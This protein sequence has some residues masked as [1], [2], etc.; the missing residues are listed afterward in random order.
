M[1][2]FLEILKTYWGYDSFRSLQDEIILSVAGG[3]DTLGLMPT[4]GGKSLTFQVPVMSMEGICIVVTPLI[5]LMK[6][7]VDNLRDRGIKAAAI[8]SGMS[9]QEIITALENC[10]FGNYKFLYISP[11]RLTTE[12]FL[13]KIQYM[14]VCLLVVDESHCISQWGY[15]FR[16][17]Y[18]NIAAIRDY[19][20]EV[21][22][23]ALTAT[24]TE[25]VVADIQEKLLFREKNVFRKSFERINIAYIVRKTEDK[26]YEMIHILSRIEGS[27][28]VYVR[29]RKKT[30][31]I[32][33][34]LSDHHI[35]ADFFHAGLSSDEKIIRQ[36]KWKS[37]ETRVMVCTNAFG[38]GIDKPDVRIVIHY[39]MPGSLEEYFQEAGRAG[40]DGQKSYA[41]ALYSEKD[42]QR[43]KKRVDDEFPARDFI[44][45]I[46][47]K[48]AYYF[49]L[50]VNTG[51]QTTYNFDLED[52]C[53]VFKFSFSQ[54]HYALKLLQLAGYIEYVEETDKQS[55]LIFTVNRDDLYDLSE[56]NKKTE[57]LIQVIL[58]SYTG[59]FAE[60]VY[61]NESLL[62]NRSGL[63]HHEVYETLKMLSKRRIIH[64][65]PAQKIPM[66]IYLQNRID[67]KY[68][69]I[70]A[71]VYEDRKNR[72]K[73]RIEGVIN[74]GSSESRCRSRL[75]L[76]YFGERS[77]S[78]CGH[79]DVCLKKKQN[80]IPEN[81]HKKI[82]NEILSLIGK[83]RVSFED[84]ISELSSYP[85]N[86]IVKLI[87]FLSDSGKIVL[88][89]NFVYIKE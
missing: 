45:N 29:S 21:P 1:D 76:E 87:R 55:R 58:R 18:L 86:L 14:N 68:L 67:I 60:Y 54:T 62:A 3:K 73:N 22:V 9:R 13:V 51:E 25:D 66:I 37:G 56:F 4:G 47:E 23:L 7:Q 16:P 65:I 88:S 10:I 28:I 72:L 80:D 63:S 17:S 41:V 77:S 57:F 78:D 5:A 71:S 27:G 79:C 11:E 31:E 19:F 64:Y 89:G 20:P 2:K 70:P 35:N 69:S 43:L 49:Q 81:Q 53:A 74:Y 15:D 61:I 44:K 52:F 75:L 50:A 26:L 33:T 39:E 36:N 40:R 85:E 48:L 34:E 24:A 59:L 6:D 42:A 38:M 84:I 32:C 8:H 12:L 46:Y 82:I 30:Q 83:E